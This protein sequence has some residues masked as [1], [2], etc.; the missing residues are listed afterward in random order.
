MAK[1]NK[2]N[3]IGINDGV[4]SVKRPRRAL[5]LKHI[6]KP[7]RKRRKYNIYGII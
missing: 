3:S 6:I 7:A 2:K 1:D 5:L 4:V